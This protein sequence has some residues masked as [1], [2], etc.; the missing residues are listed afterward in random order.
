MTNV[1][2]S[3][4]D[5]KKFKALSK[6]IKKAQKACHSQKK[7]MKSISVYLD[8]WVQS[9]FKTEG[10]KVG[11]WQKLK[12]GGRYIKGE[13]DTTAKIL[14]DTGALRLSFK[15]FASNKNAGIGSDLIY[16]KTHNY[17]YPKKKIPQ[18]RILPEH[19]DIDTDITDILNK[20]IQTDV[21]NEIEKAFHE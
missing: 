2:I 17:G 15:P 21:L 9:N 10:G 4:R 11:G 3:A 6:Q 7:P 5:K 14:Q 12:H 8:R 16:S 19:N 20:Y 1:V 13:L 18:R